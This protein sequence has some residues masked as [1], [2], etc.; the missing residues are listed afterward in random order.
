M[1]PA[2]FQ[3]FAITAFRRGS[4][5][6]DVEP[7]QDGT[8]RPYGVRVKF[9]SGTVFH[10]SI[11][12]VTPPGDKFAEPET[13]VTADPPGEVPVPSMS[14]AVT[15]QRAETYLAALLNNTG[16]PEVAR[17]YAYSA[18]D[19]PSMNPGLGVDF[20]NGGKVHLLIAA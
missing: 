9:A 18:R 7:W 20:H 5:V 17:T 3:E 6:A 14:G 2:R 4:E 10:V 16:N 19:T 11:T 13:P 8:K 12:A 1:R 15:P